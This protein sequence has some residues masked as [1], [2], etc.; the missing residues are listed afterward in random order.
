MSFGSNIV[1]YRKKHGITQEG[2]AEKLEVTRQTVSRWETDA[3]F[4]EMEKL[5]ALCGLFGCD[6]ETLVRGDAAARTADEQ[7]ANLKAYDRHMNAFAVQITAGVSLIFAGLA[8][9]LFLFAAVTGDFAGKMT[10]FCFIILS[11]ALLIAGGIAH[12]D[13]CREHL[14]REKY[15]EEEVR[16]FRGKLPLLMAGA[17]ACVLVGAAIA[18]ILARQGWDYVA[19]GAFSTTM[20]ISVGIYV[21][22]GLLSSKYGAKDRTPEDGSA[23]FSA[24]GRVNRIFVAF[25]AAV[26]FVALVIYLLLGFLGELWHPG[27]IC[28]LVGGILCGIAKIVANAYLRG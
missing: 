15:P 12:A 21:Y 1:F 2:L 28:L 17:T 27:W 10:F 6:M 25:C 23:A 22:V 24:A 8:A 4:P 19:G 18:F 3:A 9:M 16:A 13:F 26:M 20:A 5:I 11:A 14:Q 7:A